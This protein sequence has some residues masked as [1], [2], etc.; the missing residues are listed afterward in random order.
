[1]EDTTTHP[2]S[3]M[4]LQQQTIAKQ[5]EYLKHVITSA[6]FNVLTNTFSFCTGN[7]NV[8]LVSITQRV[9]KGFFIAQDIYDAYDVYFCTGGTEWTDTRSFVWRR[10]VDGHTETESICFVYFDDDQQPVLLFNAVSFV[11]ASKEKED[12]FYR[13]LFDQAKAHWKMEWKRFF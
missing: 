3:L 13:A 11:F 12:Q 2:L 8:P 6:N 5:R 10:K 4:L 7:E 1:M 9:D